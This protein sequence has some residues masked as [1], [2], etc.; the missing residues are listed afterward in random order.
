M[1][2]PEFPN[3][4][5]ATAERAAGAILSSIAAQ[6]AALG[7]ILCAE[8]EKIRHVL[9]STPPCCG[10]ADLRAIL[11]VNRSV[12]SVLELATELELILKGK[13]RLAAGLLPRGG[14]SECSAVRPQA[15]CAGCCRRCGAAR[16]FERYDNCCR[17]CPRKQ[18]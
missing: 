4:E 17:V 16:P 18:I 15:P 6:E 10:R 7:C 3:C 1:S 12:A 2:L 13:A 14:V 5:N 8:G 11:E 9:A